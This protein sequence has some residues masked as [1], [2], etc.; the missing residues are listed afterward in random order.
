MISLPFPAW[1]RRDGRYAVNPCVI[2]EFATPSESSIAR[3]VDVPWTVEKSGDNAFFPDTIAQ[4]RP[5]GL[6]YHRGTIFDD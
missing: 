2:F 4:S 6:Y 3:G 5:V 1:F